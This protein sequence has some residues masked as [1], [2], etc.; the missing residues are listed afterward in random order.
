MNCAERIGK[1]FAGEFVDCVP[2]ALKGWR[3]PHDE[4]EAALLRDGMC[5]IDSAGVYRTT[6]PNVRH[7]SESYERN[8]ATYTRT[9]VHTPKGSVS[10]VHSRVPSPK[11]E[12][13]TWRV[14]YPF[15]TSDDYAAVEFMMCDR[16]YSPD[17]DG[18]LAAQAKSEGRAFFKT[19]APGS[20]LHTIMYTIM[21]LDTF[22]VEWAERRDRVV[23]LHD[24][25]LAN[26]RLI[27]PIIGRSPAKVVQSGGNY[28]PEVLGKA[29]MVEFLLPHWEELG[30][31]LHAG[32][33]LF[34]S[35]LD[36]N[37]A[38]WADE[39]ANSPLDWIEA[40]TPDP[41]SD[42]T[43]AEAREK[44]PGK[45]L[46]INFPSSVHLRDIDAIE[47]ETRRLL[48]E[49]APGDRFIIGIT[50]NVPENCWRESFAAILRTANEFGRLP[51]A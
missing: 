30:E 32:G 33:K 15:K 25:I 21:G 6:S 24:A 49:S 31:V 9:T 12:A 39:V 4:A 11:V 47:A 22:A 16:Q 20:P 27:Y 17:Y 26:E 28:A 29:R 38:L 48:R 18:F 1:V 35:H 23:A 42:M 41:D 3:V 19:G 50:E 13:T 45:T 40:F 51:I 36:A 46:F 44:W 37:N 2:F 10:S 43:L 7:E 34:G 5:V 8:G 14:E